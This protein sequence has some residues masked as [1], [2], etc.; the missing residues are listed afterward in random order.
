MPKQLSDALAMLPDFVIQTRSDYSLAGELLEVLSDNVELLTEEEI[1][2]A[3][4]L[5]NMAADFPVEQLV[6]G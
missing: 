4:K 1:R 2:L 5:A 6:S 3:T